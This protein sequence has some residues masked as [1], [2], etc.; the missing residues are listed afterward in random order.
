MHLVF[1]IFFLKGTVEVAE[2]GIVY[3]TWHSDQSPA[4][5]FLLIDQRP[6]FAIKQKVFELLEWNKNELAGN[7]AAQFFNTLYI[8]NM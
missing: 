4:I 8:E 3:Y 6:F 7:E 2:S 5:V 1:S